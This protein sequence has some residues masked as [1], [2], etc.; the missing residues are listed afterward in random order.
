MNAMIVETCFVEATEDVALYRRLGADAI[1]KSIAE[2]IANKK[3]QIVN[4]PANQSNNGVGYR[5]R[6]TA[7][8]LNVR[9]GAGTNYSIATTV[10]KNDV[11]T[12][13]EEKNGWGKLKSGVGF[14]CLDYTQRL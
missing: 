7:S 4:A 9:K 11:Y 2:A 5:V 14:I 12:I 1:G 8:V 10:K 6:I 13:V 3:V